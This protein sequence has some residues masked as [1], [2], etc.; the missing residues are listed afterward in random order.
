M[1]ILLL[2]V[3]AAPLFAQVPDFSSPSTSAPAAPANVAASA[4]GSTVRI[5]AIPMRTGDLE[6]YI[7]GS[8]VP[9]EVVA[10]VARDVMGCKWR[11]T[12]HDE[13]SI[14]GVCEKWLHGDATYR[15]GSVQL[16]PLVIVL[17][18]AGAGVVNIKLRAS[19]PPPPTMPRGWRKEVVKSSQIQRFL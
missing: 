15:E 12:Y 18:A 9:P 8:L 14:Y 6:I 16:A 11:E 10:R 3:A 4:T 1:K 17:R 13:D 5:D 7:D 19:G 2:L